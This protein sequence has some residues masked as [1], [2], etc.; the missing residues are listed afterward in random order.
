ME[1]EDQ[2]RKSHQSEAFVCNPGE[3]HTAW[4]SRP[5][6]G[7]TKDMPRKSRLKSQSEGEGT[8]KRSTEVD[9][10]YEGRKLR[11]L[12]LTVSILIFCEVDHLLRKGRKKIADVN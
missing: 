5:L 11:W 9:R 6:V 10:G 12:T 2:R 8:R 7:F 4:L 1:E 3:D